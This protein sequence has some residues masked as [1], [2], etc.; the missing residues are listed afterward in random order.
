MPH[1]NTLERS[2]AFKD[3]SRSEQWERSDQ[4]LLEMLRIDKLSNQTLTATEQVTFGQGIAQGDEE[5]KNEYIMRQLRTAMTIAIKKFEQQ[6]PAAINLTVEDHFQEVIEKIKKSLDDYDDNK[7]PD[8]MSYISHQLKWIQGSQATE[9]TALPLTGLGGR[10]QSKDATNEPIIK[11]G[12][13][14]LES[15]KGTQGSGTPEIIE[16]ISLKEAMVNLGAAAKKLTDRER[17][18]LVMRNG[19]DRDKPATL[20]EIG[21]EFNFTKEY[22]RQ[23]EQSSIRNT[24]RTPKGQALKGAFEESPEADYLQQTLPPSQR[25]IAL[26][27]RRLEQIRSWEDSKDPEY[28][29]R[30]RA[31]KAFV[32]AW[33]EEEMRTPVRPKITQTETARARFKIARAKSQAKNLVKK[34]SSD[35]ERL[36]Q[37]KGEIIEPQRDLKNTQ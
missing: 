24:K 16:R 7:F 33:G 27:R 12:C 17:R 11:E 1:E 6:K 19:I 25:K 23:I 29:L 3:L 2:K 32:D 30:F 31:L 15:L 35:E 4:A 14:E 37:L 8:F 28:R 21:R 20:D 9:I 26:S 34:I 5:A 13:V 10:Y 36:A 18:I 22:I